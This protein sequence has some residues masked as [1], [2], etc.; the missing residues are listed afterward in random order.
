MRKVRWTAFRATPG[1]T[2]G[3]LHKT[4]RAAEKCMEKEQKKYGGKWHVS[5]ATYSH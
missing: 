4:K 5:S 3:H 2:C 1:R